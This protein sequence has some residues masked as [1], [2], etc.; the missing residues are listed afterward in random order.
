[1]KIPQYVLNLMDRSKY[2]YDCFK[3]NQN[4][5]V[6]YTIK[7]QK[8]TAYTRVSTFRD[9]IEKLKKW[10]ERNGGELVIIDFPRYTHYTTQ[11][12]TV[13]IYDPVMRYIESYIG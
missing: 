5:A 8:A 1:M 2:E 4:Y 9:E 13:T 12:A 10:V 7:I 6:G 11:T 3:S